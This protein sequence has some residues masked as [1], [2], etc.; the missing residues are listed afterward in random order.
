[1]DT[2]I[3]LRIAAL[4]AAALLAV[5]CIYPFKVD[6]RR[7]G[8]YPLVIEGDILVGA[9][10]TVKLSHVRPFDVSGY[11]S[12]PIQAE[13]YI[14]GEDGTRVDGTPVDDPTIPAGKMQLAFDTSHL[15]EGQRYRL[16]INTLSGSN[17]I[18][19]E[20]ESDWLTPC[21]APTID[22]LTYSLHDEFDELW[23]GLSMHCNGSHYFRWSFT[24]T[25]EYHSDVHSHVEYVPQTRRWDEFSRKYVYSGGYYQTAYPTLYYCW[26]T[27][28]SPQINIFSTANQTED[29]FE[30]LAFH[31]I[32]LSD[33]RL[34][35]LYRITVNLQ[36]LSEDAYNYWNNIVQNSSD[37]GSIFAPVPS[38]MAS[39]V[40]CISDPTVQVMGYLNAA[41]PAR[42]VMY[43]DNSVEQFFRPPLPFTRADTTI[44]YNNISLA[45]ELYRGGF[46]PYHEEYN[47]IV[48]DDETGAMIPSD[49]TWAMAICI[50]CRLQ[51]GTK[52][53]P[54]DWPDGNQ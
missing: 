3:L 25:W 8:E 11:E 34:Q 54:A 35:V 7:D 12:V 19:N 29:R 14:E 52:K 36:A 15:Q 53:K 45:E 20:F 21:P 50:D 10:T 5:T 32:P 13:G 26:D 24:E 6:I 43:Y 31:T 17:I 48:V 51:G 44:A 37:Q 23:V 39:N 47:S 9:I 38:E 2:R 16:H 41:V 33:K 22:A 49:Y 40:R 1:M 27:Q 46:L 28:T 18:S 42:A 30:K 4:S